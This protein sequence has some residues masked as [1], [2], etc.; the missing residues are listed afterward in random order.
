M[1]CTGPTLNF[2]TSSYKYSD[3]CWSCVMKEEEGVT[4]QKEALLL[5]KDTSPE[6]RGTKTTGRRIQGTY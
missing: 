5:I 1:E 2:T 3:R 6:C 4:S